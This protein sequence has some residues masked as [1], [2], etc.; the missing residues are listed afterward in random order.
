M[1]LADSIRAS[2]TRTYSGYPPSAFPC[3][4]R[5]LTVFGRLSHAVRFGKN[6]LLKVLQPQTGRNPA[7]LGSSAF[8]RHYR[9]NHCLVFFSSAYLDVSVQR[10]GSP[11]GVSSL[12]L[13]G[14]PHSD[15]L[16]SQAMCASPKL[17]AAYRVL[18]RLAEL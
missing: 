17:F 11:C 10:V 16:G 7:G 13:P 8:A 14:L 2:P 15:V 1:V 18:L 9:R 3:I 4:Y 6:T 5:A 12:Q